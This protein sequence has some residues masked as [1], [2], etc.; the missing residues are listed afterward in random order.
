MQFKNLT[1]Y[2]TNMCID[3]QIFLKAKK[4]FILDVYLK[5]H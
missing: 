4:L 3:G 5:V 2:S 1:M